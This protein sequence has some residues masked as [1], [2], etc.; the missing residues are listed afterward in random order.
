MIPLSD[1]MKTGTKVLEIL[2]EGGRHM[3]RKI[4]VKRIMQLRAAGLSQ[5][6]IAR[7]NHMS[8][9]S[10]SEV[11]RIAQE[12]QISFADVEGKSNE[13]AYR[14]FF[15]DKH[16]EETI[17]EQ[18]D[19]ATVHKELP[20]TGVTL[21]LLWKEYRD[22]CKH[23]GLTSYG[24]TRFCN[25]YSEFTIS[26]N[27][28]NRLSHKPGAV[29]EVDWSGA[30][31]HLVSPLTGEDIPVYLFVAVLPYSQYAYIELCLDMKEESWLR[32]NVHMFEFWGGS[33]TRIVC[34]N[35]KTG[36][37][38]HPKEGEIVLNEAYEA[39]AN[40][41]MTAIMPA[42][43]RK[44][45]QKASVEGTVG[46]IAT[47]VIA[48]LR[49]ETFQ[50]MDSM[51]TAVANA[52]G[53]YNCAPFQKREGSRIQ[54]FREEEA[55]YLRPLP[56]LPYEIATWKYG[57]SVYPDCH[58][59]LD[60]N[61]Y[62]CPYQ[63]A[64]K[65]VDL[66]ITDTLLEIYLSGERIATHR[67]FPDYLSNQWSTRSEDMPDQFQQ[68]EWDDERIRKWAKTIGSATTEVIDR[69]FADL[70]IKEQGYNPCMAVLRLSKKYSATRLEA[71]C[72]LA[73]TRFHSP[74]YRHLQAILSAEEDI[75]FQSQEKEKQREQD[76]ETQGY[77]RGA[78]YYGGLNHD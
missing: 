43:V 5:S 61:H 18:P 7:D 28:T 8:K 32:C 67:R 75:L 9:T 47:A 69:I 30:T 33:T 51:R 45:K 21:K 24:Y 55:A 60:K 53:D 2:S 57:R 68:M 27:L 3:A 10:V 17:Y 62:S 54:V 12:R 74:R 4:R 40:H 34:D 22:R 66:K 11:F 29:S 37:I 39:L 16:P 56:A 73:L 70:Q 65:K 71:A 44:P 49:D 58:V 31:M 15:P 46:K 25:G 26:Q 41:Y 38:N 14:M 42:Q 76:K 72:A 1:K 48:R 78:A 64:G 50:T 6:E 35:L 59:V 63:Y 23:H 20:R 19:Y 36:V 77:I 13:E 52:L